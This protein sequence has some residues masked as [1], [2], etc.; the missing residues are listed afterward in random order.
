MLLVVAKGRGL[1]RLIEAFLT[2]LGEGNP[3]AWLFLI[4]LILVMG[5]TGGV[6]A[7]KRRERKRVLEELAAKRAARPESEKPARKK[8]P[9]PEKERSPEQEALRSKA[10]KARSRPRFDWHEGE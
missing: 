1:G 3:S 6:T 7:Y 8:Q 4:G 9:K 10:P 2:E 5:I